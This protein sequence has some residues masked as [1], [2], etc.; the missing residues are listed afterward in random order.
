ML[1][2]IEKGKK[3][4][5]TALDGR[6]IMTLLVG[7]VRA[8]RFCDCALL[9]FCDSGHVERWLLRLRSINQ[10]DGKFGRQHT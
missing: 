5:V 10:A 9:D 2:N 7:A 1:S 8:A 6:A 4:D 3:A